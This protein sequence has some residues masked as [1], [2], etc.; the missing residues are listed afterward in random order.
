MEVYQMEVVSGTSILSIWSA[1]SNGLCIFGAFIS[2]SY[3]GRFRVIATG[4][5]SALL[6]CQNH[7][8]LLFHLSLQFY[9]IGYSFYK[10][11]LLYE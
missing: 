1:L 10:C 9:I 7:P 2:D 11:S 6:V 4:S 3:L 8:I 5:F